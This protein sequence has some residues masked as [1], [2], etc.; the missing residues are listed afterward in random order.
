M[1]PGDLELAQGSGALR[2]WLL[3]LLIGYWGVEHTAA[4]AGFVQ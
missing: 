4:W 1:L 2:F 3:W